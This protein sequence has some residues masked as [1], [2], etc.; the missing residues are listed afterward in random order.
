MEQYINPFIDYGFKKLF[1]TE[2]NKDLLISLLNAIIED[3]DDPVVDLIYKNV[4]QISDYNGTRTNY[5]DVYCETKSKRE[6]IVEMQN[7]WKP[8]FKDRTVYYA[9]KPIR[10]QGLMGIQKSEDQIRREQ[11]AKRI[12]EDL[13]EIEEKR[14]REFKK[15]GKPWNFR[16]HDVYL[17][18]IMNFTFS[19]KEYEP[20]SYFHKVMLTDID[21]HHVFYD[22]L[23]LYYVEMP[24][25]DNI[26]L[27]LDTPRE[28]WLYALYNLWCGNDRP[29]ELDEDIFHK[30]YEQARIAC[31]TPEQQFAYEDSRMHYLDTYAEIEGGFIMG[32]E[33][34][35]EWGYKDGL[36]KS[37]EEGF[38]KGREEG[39]EKTK[40]KIAK[41]LKAIGIDKETILKSAEITEEEYDH[42]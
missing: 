36:K 37:R 34:G 27:K 4:E 29:K 38:E 3:D 18:A 20:E 30:L 21:D 5:F 17:I 42:I 16:L 2:P 13:K 31:F 11:F 10:N 35:Y 23:T 24:K 15:S 12:E 14:E 41:R 1:A 9:A 22:K 19:R 26:E 32:R 39:Y 25:L 33:Q 28:K 7:S 6:F 40:I 8:F